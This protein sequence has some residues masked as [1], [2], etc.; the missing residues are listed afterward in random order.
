[1][2]LHGQKWTVLTGP[3][4]GRLQC[5][6]RARWSLELE[7]RRS[8]GAEQE[9]PGEPT[10]AADFVTPLESFLALEA[11]GQSPFRKLPS[12]CSVED[13]QEADVM[14]VAFRAWTQAGA[15]RRERQGCQEILK[16]GP[17]E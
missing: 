15:P 14:A 7:P 13:W 1:M 16:G 11:P 9:E 12:G 5:Q 4:Q 17:V 3:G 6:W 2:A 8:V 10:A